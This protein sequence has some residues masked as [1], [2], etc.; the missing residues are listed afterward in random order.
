MRETL[1]DNARRSPISSRRCAW[2]PVATT[3]D[4]RGAVLARLCPRP[5]GQ[6]ALG[7]ADTPCRGTRRSASAP[8]AMNMRSVATGRLCAGARYLHLGA[9]AAARGEDA[10]RAGGHAAQPRSGA[11]EPRRVVRGTPLVHRVARDRARDPLCARRG[12]C[13]ARAG[14][15]RQRARQLARCTRYAEA[16]AG[17]AAEHTGCTPARADRPGARHRAAR[18]RRARRERRGA[19]RGDRGLQER[20]GARRA[21]DELRRACRGG[22]RARRLAFRLH[23]TRAR[24]AGRRAAAAQPDRPAL[25]D[26]ARGFD[27]A[28]KEARTHC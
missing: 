26:A 12:V 7:L 10:A 2:P 19:A 27:T 16:G 13:T 5:A 23:A 21:R 17:A 9:G 1:G 15:G 8:T 24:E 11:R 3:D 14:G 18:R 22:G 25:R 28:S 6:Y 4:R 20:R